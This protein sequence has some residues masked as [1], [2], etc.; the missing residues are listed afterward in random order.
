MQWLPGKTSIFGFDNDY[1]E[2]DMDAP[3]FDLE[4]GEGQEECKGD[5]TVAKKQPSVEN[6]C[7][8]GLGNNEKLSKE[9]LINHGFKLMN[10]GT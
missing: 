5:A 1:D 3:V 6:N 9:A 8:I 7:F 4:D 10:R 2:N